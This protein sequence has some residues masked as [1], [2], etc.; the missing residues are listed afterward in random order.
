MKYRQFVYNQAI[1]N[2]IYLRSGCSSALITVVENQILYKNLSEHACL[3]PL[4]VQISG[5][6]D[7]HVSNVIYRSE[8]G[9]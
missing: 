7:C 3:S 9:K 4:G 6:E 5:F 2:G 1:K 8:M